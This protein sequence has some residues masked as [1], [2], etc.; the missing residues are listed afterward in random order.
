M[1][2]LPLIDVIGVVP[3]DNY[4]L[5]ILFEDDVLKLFDCTRFLRDDTVFEP[6]KDP[7]KFAEAH[8]ALGTVVWPGRVDLDLELLYEQ[9]VAVESLVG[10]ALTVRQEEQLLAML[11]ASPVWQGN[12]ALVLHYE[13]RRR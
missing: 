1:T 11:L 12:D 13:S 7:A 3:L 8:V 5:L 4:K 9:G 6:I 10:V 2:T